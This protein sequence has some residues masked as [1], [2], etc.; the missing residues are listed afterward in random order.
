RK[1]T[2]NTKGG[3]TRTIT[4]D[5]LDEKDTRMNLGLKT[6]LGVP[7][8]D[9]A[10]PTVEQLETT[11]STIGKSVESQTGSI[12]F[13]GGATVMNAIKGFFAWLKNGFAGGF[14]GL[15]HSIAMVTA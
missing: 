10:V 6:K 9:N 11:A 12:G 8:L 1:I 2:F 15:K 3:F 13:L 4:L 5:E 7:H 14:D